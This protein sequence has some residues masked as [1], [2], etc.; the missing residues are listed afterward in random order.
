MSPTPPGMTTPSREP[1]V[2]QG[3]GEL[4][5]GLSTGRLLIVVAPILALVGATALMALAAW[6]FGWYRPEM[7][8]A[9]MGA[10]GVAVAVATAL[11]YSQ[12]R[13]QRASLVALK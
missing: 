8:L 5:V 10:G 6:I 7:L 1:V 13:H 9:A 11:L 3:P 12:I 4:P 2:G